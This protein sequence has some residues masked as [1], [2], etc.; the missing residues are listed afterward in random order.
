MAAANYKD[1]ITIINDVQERLGLD[2]TTDI[3]T[4]H[5]RTLL[6]LLNELIAEIHDYGDWQQYYEEILVT[7]ATSVRQYSIS[8][9]GRE[10]HNI[11]D[12]SFGGQAGELDNNSIVDI[13]RLRRVS[14]GATGNPRQYAL[15]D[16]DTSGNPRI[17]VY[18]MPGTNEN[19]KT[20]DIAVYAREPL[21]AASDTAKVL[22]F[23]GNLLVQG[24][25]AKAL[26]EENSGENTRQSQTAYAEYLRFL[27]EA[28]NR[29]TRDTENTV[30]FMPGRR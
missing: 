14:N 13:R 4:K 9:S 7:A 28:Q 12:V 24:L 11:L 3:T 18:P 8:V 1:V 6:Q 21:L 20:F 19:G 30:R 2:T 22:K 15:I 26:V 17:E 25:Y 10:V 29:F 16:V 5:A 23:P 27:R